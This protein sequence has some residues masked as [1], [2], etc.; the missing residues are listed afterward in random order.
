MSD[1]DQPAPDWG[2]PLKLGPIMVAQGTALTVGQA[3]VV[4]GIEFASF[5]EEDSGIQLLGIHFGKKV[6]NGVLVEFHGDPFVFDAVGVA[7]L[8]LGVMYQLRGLPDMRLEV[9]EMM[10]KIF[11]DIPKSNG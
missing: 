11:D 9:I 2:P 3:L 1:Q 5:T 8:F 10:G 7:N 4:H 6:E